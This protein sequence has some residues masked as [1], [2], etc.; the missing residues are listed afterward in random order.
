MTKPVEH[1]ARDI[2]LGVETVSAEHVVHLLADLAFI[3]GVGNCQ[4]FSPSP[5]PLFPRGKAGFGVIHKKSQ[6]SREIGPGDG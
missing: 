5:V 1:D 6:D 4:H 2:A 3:F